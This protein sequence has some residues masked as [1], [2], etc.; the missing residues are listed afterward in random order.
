MSPQ[1]TE[2]PRSD[3]GA[4]RVSSH[5]CR[6]AM[7]APRSSKTHEA[8]EWSDRMITASIRAELRHT[9][10]YIYTN[11]CCIHP[12]R[13]CFNFVKNLFFLKTSQ[14]LSEASAETPCR[15]CFHRSIMRKTRSVSGERWWCPDGSRR[16]GGVICN[17]SERFTRLLS[18]ITTNEVWPWSQPELSLT[19]AR[20]WSLD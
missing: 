16:Y 19:E 7:E 5:S 13:V 4:L 3:V 10:T 1:I 12:A 15:F 14:C 18:L 6:P 2:R 20:S 8:A 11:I 9:Y 17:D